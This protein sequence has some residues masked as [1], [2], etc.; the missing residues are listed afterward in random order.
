MAWGAWRSRWRGN[1]AYV[2]TPRLLEAGH[3]LPAADGV[4][5]A[6]QAPASLFAPT[7]QEPPLWARKAAGDDRCLELNVRPASEGKSCRHISVSGWGGTGST[8]LHN[9]LRAIAPKGVTISKDHNLEAAT[10]NACTLLPVRD[11]RDSLCSNIKRLMNCFNCTAGE[12]E[13]LIVER[14]DDVI[15][16]IVDMKDFYELVYHFRELAPPPPLCRVEVFPSVFQV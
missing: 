9:M 6:F 11:F 10:W 5:S 8:Y 15:K 4:W 7:T 16:D 14:Y 2:G 13:A 3:F 12:V 1:D